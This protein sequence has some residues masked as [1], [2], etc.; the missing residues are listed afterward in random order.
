MIKKVALVTGASSGIGEATV[1]RLLSA[2]YEVYAA[3]RRVPR[4]AGLEECGATLIALDLV[5]EISIIACIERIKQQ[6]GRLD[7]VVNN[8]GY[9]SY[10]ALEDVP[11]AEARRQM[12]VNL[13]GLA[14][15]CQ[16]ALPIM[17]KQ[18]SGVIINITSIGGKFGEPF[19]SWYHATK[20]AVEGLS[21]CLRMEARPFG[22][23]VVVIEPGAIKTEWNK[24]ARD[25]LISASGEGAYG[26]YVRRHAAM[27]SSADKG[28]YASPATVVADTVWKAVTARNPR[29]RYAVGGGAKIILSMLWLV[30]DR[31]L[32]K[33]V[34]KMS[35][36]NS[37]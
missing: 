5:D 36:G 16:L 9:G 24:I 2:G 25:S 31:M 6:S 12:E 4:M 14:H 17:R 7:V 15:I 35:Q 21:D 29:P 20:F 27:L 10:G 19:G 1:L 33:I 13:F 32:D 22:I 26:T 3:A 11:M 23:D 34:W 8:A 28:R 18:K 37:K 30:P